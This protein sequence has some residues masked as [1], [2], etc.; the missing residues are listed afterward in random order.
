MIL[1]RRIVLAIAAIFF[2]VQHFLIRSLRRR[3]FAK[4]DAIMSS[5]PHRMGIPHRSDPTGGWNRP[6]P[7]QA[8][9]DTR[10]LDWRINDPPHSILY[11]PTLILAHGSTAINE[12]LNYVAD[13]LLYAVAAL[14]LASAV[15]R[16]PD[17]VE[18]T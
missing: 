10:S 11:L 12:G 14:V 6:G 17:R 1:F 15:P 7:E 3:S 5:I 16:D 18:K 4:V 9:S 2:A 13:T 8:I